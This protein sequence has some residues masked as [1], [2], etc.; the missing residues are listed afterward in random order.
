MRKLRTTI[1]M[2][3]MMGLATGVAL[4]QTPP[5]PATPAPAPAKP[6][7]PAPAPTPPK[8]DPA[9]GAPGTPPKPADKAP[10]TDANAKKEPAPA[11]MPAPKPPQEVL[12][13]TKAST[14]TWR[15]KGTVWM[16][17]G[18]SRPTAGTIKNKADLDKF[19]IQM[20]FAET[21]PAKVK[22]KF[23]AYR[24]FDTASK[25]WTE[26]SVD[27]MGGYSVSTSDGPKDNVIAWEGTAH[28]MGMTMKSKGNETLVSAKE[29]KMAG[30][31][32]MDG[33]KTWV[34]SYDVDCKK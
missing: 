18:T 8:A 2:V 13:A 33:G 34:N 24:T 11:E 3:A 6:A 25:K 16:P 14:G 27:N 15:C 30:Q 26:V 5:K 21:G 17:D 9:K 31:A 4:A 10:A 7:T 19:W 32:S 29:I 28:G 23:T 1:A 12:D 22:Y 20:S